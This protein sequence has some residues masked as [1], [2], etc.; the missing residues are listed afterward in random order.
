MLSLNYVLKQLT[1]TAALHKQVNTV[2]VG[3]AYDFSAS[4]ALLYPCAWCVPQSIV[5]LAGANSLIGNAIEYHIQ[6][7]MMD[8]E[9]NDG[10]NEVDI[11]SDCALILLDI[12]AE[13]ESNLND[14][15]QLNLTSFSTFEP[16]VDAR[17]D[18]V[19][20]YSTELVFT[21]FYAKDTCTDIFN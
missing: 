17:L 6:V 19:S 10:T 15:N 13:I 4:E 21:A 16:F 18:T 3:Q 11:L 7:F 9:N 5:P 12:I 14:T 20:G 1:D 8:L 2:A